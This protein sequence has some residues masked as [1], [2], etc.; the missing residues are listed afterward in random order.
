[1]EGGRPRF[2]HRATAP[3]LL[4]LAFLGLTIWLAG[5]LWFA[6]QLPKSPS[7]DL[8]E[9][10]V[11]V[12]LTGGSGRLEEGLRLLA[13]GRAQKLF[14]SGVYRGLD[15]RQ[16]LDLF[17]TSPGDLECCVVLGYEADDTRGNAQETA[18]WMRDEGLISL[19]L[20]T[21][22]YHMPRS[23]FEFDRVLPEV[24]LIS[25]PVFP[26][27]YRQ[28]DWWRWPGS[29]RLVVSEYHKYLVARLRG[30]LLGAQL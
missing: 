4:L 18:A 30:V 1:M 22:A 17:Q 9:T 24:R 2:R 21:A 15:V 16:L 12:V 29:A 8:S 19:R 20:V 23:R 6:E 13:A 26:A 10:E 27:T 5:L 28:N 7:D 11:I 14:V 25:H 3:R